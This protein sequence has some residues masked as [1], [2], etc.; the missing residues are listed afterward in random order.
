[1]KAKVNRRLGNL[2]R[3]ERA[4]Q[5]RAEENGDEQSHAEPKKLQIRPEDQLIKGVHVSFRLNDVND[6][7]SGRHPTSYLYLLV[8]SFYAFE[9]GTF[10]FV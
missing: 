8:F 3:K 7:A 2:R 10:D 9:F 4:K 6:S 5:I 1:M